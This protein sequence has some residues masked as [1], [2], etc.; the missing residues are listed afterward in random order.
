MACVSRCQQRNGLWRSVDGGTCVWGCGE[1]LG[2]GGEIMICV[3]GGDAG[4]R[5]EMRGEMTISHLGGEI[6]QLGARAHPAALGER[7]LWGTEEAP[8]AVERRGLW[9]T[10]RGLWTT[11]RA[12]ENERAVDNG[13][14]CGK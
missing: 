13:E 5:G 14:G 10:E 12:V 6:E 8:S 11:E 4:R 9:T 3:W 7:H 1:M 2:D